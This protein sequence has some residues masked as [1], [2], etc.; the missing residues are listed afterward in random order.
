MTAQVAVK[1][2]LVAVDTAQVA[3]R[4]AQDA[5]QLEGCLP[6]AHQRGEGTSAGRHQ[7]PAHERL[8]GARD[9]AALSSGIATNSVSAGAVSSI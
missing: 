6:A 4:S 7:E 1:T 2:A 5:V 3:F 8:Q 9:L